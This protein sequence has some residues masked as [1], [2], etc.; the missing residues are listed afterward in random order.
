MNTVAELPSYISF[1]EKHLSSEE[2]Q[3]IIDFLAKNPNFITT[4][5]RY[6]W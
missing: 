1:A 4:D 5:Y 2:R 3:D 6:I